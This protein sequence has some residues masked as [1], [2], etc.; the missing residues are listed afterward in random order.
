MNSEASRTHEAATGTPGF[1][2]RRIRYELIVCGLR[3]HFLVGIRAAAVR[4]DDRHLVRE[5]EGV[6]WHRCLRCDAWV[7][8]PRGP[9]SAETSPAVEPFPPDLE[10]VEVPL[11]GRALRDKVVLRLIAIDRAFHF[12]VLALVSAGLLLVAAH[13]G[14][15]RGSFY[16]VLS[17]LQGPVAAS[18]HPSHGLVKELDKVL[19]LRAGTLHTVALVAAAYALLE[20]L[21]AVGLWYSKRWAEYLT[22]LATAALLPLEVYELS[23]RLSPLKILAFVINVLVV[24]Y[25]LYAKRLFGLRGGADAD[26][27]ERERDGG[28]PAVRQATPRATEAQG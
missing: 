10:T 11:R 16:R 1:D 2:R 4:A 12:I 7:A 22:F 8:V 6:R 17:D 9:V 26:R 19:S 15:L 21:E 5:I 23:S 24:V 13:Q 28:W 20:G 27:R 18:T 3:G 14:E 25:L